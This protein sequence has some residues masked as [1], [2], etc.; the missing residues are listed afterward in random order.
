MQGT[1]VCLSVR[2]AHPN[3]LFSPGFFL[4]DEVRSWGLV[5]KGELK[6]ARHRPLLLF[7]SVNLWLVL[8]YLE[9]KLMV[10]FS[11]LDCYQIIWSR[12]ARAEFPA[13]PRTR[14]RRHRSDAAGDVFGEPWARLWAKCLLQILSLRLHNRPLR[15]CFV[16]TDEELRLREVSSAAQDHS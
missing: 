7:N 16:C 5:G 10:W 11:S 13:S 2:T 15:L 14:R 9:G 8:L 3:P 12:R 4:K 6:K 1:Q